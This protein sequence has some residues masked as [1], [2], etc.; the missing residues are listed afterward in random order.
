MDEWLRYSRR[1]SHRNQGSMMRKLLAILLVT[2][3]T[4][5]W[6]AHTY[7]VSSSLGSDAN[8]ST[9]SQSKTTPWAHLPGMATCASACASYT[10]VAG[11][12]FILYGG[13]TWTNSNFPIM[14]TWSGSTGNVI[15]I[16]VDK[17]WHSGGS[18]VQPIFTAG[19]TLINTGTENVFLAMNSASTYVTVDNIEMTGFYW[20]GA[21]A[22]GHLGYIDIRTSDY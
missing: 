9:Q 6:A 3:S 5:L 7:Y 12:Q 15:Y 18:W 20:T 21:G 13:D 17:T 1:I 22:F 8:T 19:A 14:W 4:P 10:P 2:V 11:D 16:G